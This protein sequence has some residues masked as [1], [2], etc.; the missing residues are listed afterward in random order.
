MRSTAP[1][2]AYQ[3]GGGWFHGLGGV[4]F[5]KYTNKF[6][7]FQILP[8]QI[9]YIPGVWVKKN[10]TN[11]RVIF[12]FLKFIIISIIFSFHQKLKYSSICEYW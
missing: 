6:R 8:T 4:C 7:D 10:W 1:N 5:Y 3:K 9:N 11:K 12:K 2:S